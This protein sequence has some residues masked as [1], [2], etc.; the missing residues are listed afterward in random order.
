[1]A[2]L[3]DASRLVP[4]RNRNRALT[5]RA[6]QT[7]IPTSHFTHTL[8]E[9]TYSATRPIH[10]AATAK[11][12]S[13]SVLDT[14]PSSNNSRAQHKYSPLPIRRP[15]RTRRPRCLRPVRPLLLRTARVPCRKDTLLPRLQATRQPRP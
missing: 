6:T 7:F 1:M 14:T 13:A 15:H 8:T 3:A 4:L 5:K 12:A 11:R 2:R 9:Y 10:R